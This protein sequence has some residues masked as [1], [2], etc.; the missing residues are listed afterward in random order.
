MSEWRPPA[1]AV[2]FDGTLVKKPPLGFFT[3]LDH[4]K[5]IPLML[6]RVKEWLRQKQDVWIFT[7]RVAPSLGS[8]DRES[9]KF[10][11][12]LIEEWCVKHLGQALPVT[13][14]KYRFF[15]QFWDDRAMAVEENTGRILGGTPRD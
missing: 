14:N 15:V 1:I 5:P 2:D 4:L 13:A 9:E 6:N 8:N 12:N 3:E 11:R 10:Q 7:A